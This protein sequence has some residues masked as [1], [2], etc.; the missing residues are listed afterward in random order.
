MH[1]N[2]DNFFI[3]MNCLLNNKTVVGCL[4]RINKDCH[5][6]TFTPVS[7]LPFGIHIVYCRLW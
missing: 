1:S 6:V 7:W 5:F 4:S 3:E 2:F